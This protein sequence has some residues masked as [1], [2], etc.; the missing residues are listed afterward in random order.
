[1]NNKGWSVPLLFTCIKVS[2]FSRQAFVTLLCL[3]SQC[4]HRLLVNIDPRV[5]QRAIIINPLHSTPANPSEGKSNYSKMVVFNNQCSIPSFLAQM[6]FCGPS[7]VPCHH[8][9]VVCQSNLDKVSTTG[10]TYTSF[11]RNDPWIAHL[12]GG[13]GA[14]SLDP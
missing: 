1:M 5:P 14:V 10:W 13:G 7:Y 9:A 6:S 8:M 12:R 4:I 11:H 2:F 3:S